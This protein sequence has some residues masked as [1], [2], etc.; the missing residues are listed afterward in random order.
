M[1]ASTPY[2]ASAFAILLTL[3]HAPHAGASAKTAVKAS[4]PAP[5]AQRQFQQLMKDYYQ[6]FARNE[7]LYATIAG[8][9]RFDD[10]LGLSIGPKQRAAYDADLR[11]YS[12]RLKR[13]N[14]AQL[15]SIDRISYDILE[16]NLTSTLA[17]D[18]FPAHLLPVDPMGGL[19]SYVA[20]LASGDN[21]QP[22][23]TPAQY[24]A[25][26]NRVHQLSDWID[27]A[28]ENM[29]LGMK[30]GVVQP[31]ALTAMAIPKYDQLHSDSPE[32]SLFYTPI[33]KL[34]SGFTA[35]DKT[36]LTEAYRDEIATRLNPALARMAAFLKN[37]Y[38]P[39]GRDSAGLS[40]L[41]NGK[42]WYAE[43]VAYHTT[44]TMTPQQV[45]TL[46]LQ[47]VARIQQQF[48]LL[49]PKMGYTGAPGGL[50]KWVGEQPQY[51]PFKQDDEIIAFYR[52]LDKRMAPKLASMF[53]LQPKAPLEQRLEPEL[54][55]ASAS[56]HYTPPAA[57]GSRPGIFWS[58]VNEAT[59]YDRTRM[60]T[61]YMHEG[62]PG[63]HFQMALQLQR[64]LPDF[65]KFSFT[66]A[67]GE[68]WALY[69]E[70]LGKEMGMFDAPDQYFG[71]L[72]AEL[73]R[74]V[75][76]VV[77]TGLHDQG[78]TRE[79]AI[80]YMRETLGQDETTARIAAE[81]Y[82]ADPGQALGY[83]IGQ[84]KIAELRQKAAAA[85]GPKFA[86]ADFHRIVLEDGGMPLAVLEKKVDRWIAAGQ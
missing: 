30:T 42:A 69:A 74:A 27:Q 13:I 78:W 34:P 23:A 79:Q 52:D 64:P 65:R 31:K 55:K 8:D 38:L 54:T 70:S 68:G 56:D 22:I 43:R 21:S 86:L 7:P 75:R 5:M 80:A 40:A 51:R 57:D 66:T 44:T 9:K 84:L 32:A 73:L 28:I 71:H 24:R 37:D 17:A 16:Y 61:L 41:P 4:Q 14:P 18:A 20:I 53:S 62:R 67:F 58:V 76:L 82:M 33:K 11:R 1:R 45:H 12:E 6:T 15:S 59:A 39:A 47:E 85:L 60:T 48:A 77:D 35:A 63:H 19:P 2:Y 83:K 36:S 72:N 3:A 49:G 29:R 50:P 46:G 26:L 25:Y 81:R 10:Q